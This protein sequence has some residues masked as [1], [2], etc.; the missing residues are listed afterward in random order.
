MLAPHDRREPTQPLAVTLDL[1]GDQ[2]LELAHHSV[3]VRRDLA[4]GLDVQQIES[5][6]AGLVKDLDLA[7][8]ALLART[9]KLARLPIELDSSLARPPGERLGLS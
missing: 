7:E 2:P 4:A 3:I 1:A 5:G 8:L 6:L 9:R